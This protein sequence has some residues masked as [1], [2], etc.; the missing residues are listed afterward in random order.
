MGA[1]VN[2]VEIIGHV[3]KYEIK[4]FAT[5][6]E[7]VTLDIPCKNRYKKKGSDEWSEDVEWLKIKISYPNIIKRIKE[8]GLDKGDYVRVTGSLRTNTYTN[9]EGVEKSEMQITCDSFLRLQKATNSYKT[10][11][12]EKSTPQAEPE[13]DLF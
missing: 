9:K 6:S 7:L 4:T 2:Y 8:N 5:G 10:A 13:E 3:S 12:Q 1:T 11:P